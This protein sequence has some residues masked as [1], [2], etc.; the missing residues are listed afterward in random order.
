MKHTCILAC[1]LLAAS[2]ALAQNSATVTFVPARQVDLAA[3]RESA[4]LR[5]GV[6]Y[7]TFDNNKEYTTGVV[8]R[9]V[10]TLAEMHTDW[11][12]VWYVI[13]GSGTLVTGGSLSD[14]QTES[15]GELRGSAIVG[16][17]EQHVAPGDVITVPAGV[18][19]WVRAINGTENGKEIVYL[20]VKIA[21]PSRQ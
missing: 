19:H 10:P 15:P 12:D 14:P 9:T 16:G 7:S 18:P 5:A 11:T 2:L 13:R 17:V 1:G 21:S 8:R 20:V 6:W 3:R 4:R